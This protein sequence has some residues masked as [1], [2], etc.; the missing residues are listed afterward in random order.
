MSNGCDEHYPVV[1]APLLIAHC[2]QLLPQFIRGKHW[3]LTR[4]ARAEYCARPALPKCRQLRNG[5]RQCRREILGH[6]LIR[7]QPYHGLAESE[8]RYGAGIQLIRSRFVSLP[9]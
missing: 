8:R 9:R 2:S 7:F 1:F 3:R 6:G 5:F 4:R